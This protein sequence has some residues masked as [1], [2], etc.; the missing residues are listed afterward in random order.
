L[1]NF[2][3]RALSFLYKS[4]GGDVP[5]MDLTS[6]DLELFDD[7]NRELT[8]YTHLIEEVSDRLLCAL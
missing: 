4:Y 2:V 1:G 8:D 5:Q 7:V 3:N 6:V